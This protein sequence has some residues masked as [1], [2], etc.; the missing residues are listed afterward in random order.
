METAAETAETLA[1]GEPVVSTATGPLGPTDRFLT[2][3]EVRSEGVQ[4][5]YPRATHSTARLA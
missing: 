2:Q 4:R 3:L 5:V 1:A